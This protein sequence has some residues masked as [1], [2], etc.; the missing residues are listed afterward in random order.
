MAVLPKVSV[1]IPAYNYARFLPE[2]IESIL[3]QSFT[4]FELLIID[5]NSTD[6][7]ME[8][9]SRYAARDKRIRFSTNSENIGMIPNFNLL[10]K[11]ARG[12]YVKFVCGDDFLPSSESLRK[13]VKVIESDDSI[14]L[15]SSAYFL[16]DADSTV[17]KTM[18]LDRESK[19]IR[20]TEMINLCFIHQKNLVGSPSNVMF[21]KKSAV[22]GFNP[23]Y[24][25]LLD[26]EMWFYLLEQG[27]FAYINEPLA[28]F[29]CHPSQ[30]TEKNSVSLDALS[31]NFYL[32]NEY[33]GKPYIAI[34]MFRKKYIAY[35]NV[36][37]IWK[38]F[39]TNGLSWQKALR[40]IAN[41]TGLCNFFLLYPLYKLFKP[42]Q[43]FYRKYTARYS[44]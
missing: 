17:I 28:S 1:C 7:T 18:S 24:R 13:M 29:R 41:H 38:L 35:D 44:Q 10:L 32:Y 21:R 4:D 8:V 37:R 11:Q 16:V 31:D 3:G 22:R 34:S 42:C 30:Q 26:L 33:M 2:A 43:K 12:E 39:K 19:F 15:V 27:E 20:G 40:E 23:S 36:Y 5:N 25:Q 14:V 9:V 6:D